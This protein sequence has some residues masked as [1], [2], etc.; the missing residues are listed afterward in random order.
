MRLSR[1]RRPHFAEKRLLQR[2]AR[3][4]GA[5]RVDAAARGLLRMERR[6]GVIVHAP[7]GHRASDTA[8]VSGVNGGKLR[9][10]INWTDELKQI[11]ASGGAR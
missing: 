4:A 9:V 7:P 3:Y 6:R 8:A 11:L 5:D 2:R 1:A 10:V